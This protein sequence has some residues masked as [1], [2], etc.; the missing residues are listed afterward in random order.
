MNIAISCHLF[1]RVAVLL[2]LVLLGACASGSGIKRV[3]PP[4][5]TIQRMELQSG[6]NIVLSLRI[7][8]HSDVAMRFDTINADLELASYKATHIELKTELEVPAHSAEIVEHKFQPSDTI[9]QLFKRAL[10]EGITYRLLGSVTS[11]E[12]RRHF[13][14]ETSSRL[15]PVPGKSGEFR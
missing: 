2:I 4:Q 9:A 12:P 13:P 3:N 10:D 6:R 14:V 15:N 1:S 11:S 5:L 7:Q 8:N